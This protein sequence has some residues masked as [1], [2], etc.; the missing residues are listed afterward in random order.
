MLVLQTCNVNEK[1]KTYVIT[2]RMAGTTE[3]F[4]AASR[5]A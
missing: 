5:A 2:S 1:Y 4:L 3:I